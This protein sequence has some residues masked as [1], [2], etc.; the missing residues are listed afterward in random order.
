MMIQRDMHPSIDRRDVPSP[1]VACSWEDQPLPLVRISTCGGRRIEVLQHPAEALS[2]AHYVP[3][4]SLNPGR[5]AVPA[6]TLLKHLLS[7]PQHYRSVDW[8]LEHWYGT[9]EDHL[10]TRMDNRVSSLRGILCPSYLHGEHRDICRRQLIRLVSGSEESGNGYCL[11]AYP[12]I[13]SDIDALDWNV[14]QAC[15]ME[16]Y[17]DDP[18]PFGNAP[19]TWP[20]TVSIYQR[21]SIVIGR[22]H[23]DW[24][25]WAHYGRV[26]TP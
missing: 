16:R 7:A 20:R 17:G 3:L 5:G 14:E 12:L 19:I 22:N 4:P 26:S 21:R 15:R 1:L 8:L 23:V 9:D 10:P 6:H 13:W 18:L 24:R 11:G 25:S 2:H